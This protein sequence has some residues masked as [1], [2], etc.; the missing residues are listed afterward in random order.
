MN[1]GITLLGMPNSGKTNFMTEAVKDIN[2]FSPKISMQP[3]V[4][5]P[6]TDGHSY[7]T[8]QYIL[9]VSEDTQWQFTVCDYKG[10]L[11]KSNEDDRDELARAFSMSGSWIIF[12]D[13]D[14][15]ADGKEADE[16]IIKKIKRDSVRTLMPY[17]SSYA[18]THGER[19]P[20]L[21]F[22]ITKAKKLA[23]KFSPGR[24]QHIVMGAYE[25]LFTE[26][27]APMILLS[28]TSRY[29]TAGMAVLSLLYLEYAKTIFSDTGLR[30]LGTC[31][32]CLLDCHKKMIV[33]G[34]DRIH[35]QFEPTIIKE[36]PNRKWIA[37]LLNFFY[38][39]NGLYRAHGFSLVL[40]YGIWL[41]LFVAL[42]IKL[43]RQGDKFFKV[44]IFNIC[45]GSA[46]A[47]SWNG[48]LVSIGYA[49]WI[50]LSV[51][52]LVRFFRC[53]DDLLR[54]EVKNRL[55]KFFYNRAMK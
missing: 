10:D 24:L 25:G 53:R 52:F 36:V 28:E 26:E 29:K 31:V 2:S 54:I 46:V 42:A 17:L 48:W 9:K 3:I 41:C 15:F 7:H 51:V 32:Q 47:V 45:V 20:E 6:G 40:G 4:Q 11:L 35:Y 22:L 14:Y 21:L 50:L 34:F 13:G 16:T 43:Y 18:E 55:P 39:T 23:N 8:E 27:S 30:H 5:T 37:V 12:V 19:M 33:S 44:V 1:F 38:V 49:I